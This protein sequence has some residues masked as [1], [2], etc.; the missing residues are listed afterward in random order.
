MAAWNATTR[1]FAFRQVDDFTPRGQAVPLEI[2]H[3][4]KGDR[5]RVC[6]DKPGHV[7]V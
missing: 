3:D 4:Q 2:Q 5:L 1:D 6:T 7:N